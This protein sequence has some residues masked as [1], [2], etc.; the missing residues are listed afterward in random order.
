VGQAQSTDLLSGK[1]VSHTCIELTAESKWPFR[2]AG[3]IA[4]MVN[5]TQRFVLVGQSKLTSKLTRPAV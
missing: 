2:P 3:H 1:N 5:T 4:H